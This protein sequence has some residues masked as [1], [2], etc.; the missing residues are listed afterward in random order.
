MYKILLLLL[1]ISN[2]L[3][4][5]V[6]KTEQGYLIH[7]DDLIK[8]DLLARKGAA[9]DT[10]IRDFEDLINQISIAKRQSD[11]MAIAAQKYI[12]LLKNEVYTRDSTYQVMVNNYNDLNTKYFILKD[13]HS[14]LKRK[15]TWGSL[16]AI[17]GAVGSFFLFIK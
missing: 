15:V 13:K 9:C 11:S 14:S 16:S 1:L 7:R 5:Q 17:I 4:A 8:L 2:S 3:L 10:T 6:V 12:T